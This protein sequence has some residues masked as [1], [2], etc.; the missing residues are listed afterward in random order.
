M[1]SGNGFMQ[2]QPQMISLMITDKRVFS[3]PENV[4]KERSFMN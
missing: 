2:S 4:Y 3:T 1:S